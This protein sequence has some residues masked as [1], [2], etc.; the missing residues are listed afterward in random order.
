VSAQSRVLPDLGALRHRDYRLLWSGMLA[1]SALMPLQFTTLLLFL[2]DAAPE[3]LRLLLAGVLGAMRGGVML[4]VGIP[5]GALADRIPRRRLLLITQSVAIVA[6]AGIAGL[7]LAGVSGVGLAAIFALT[8]VAGGA[9]TVDTPA[10][11]AFVPQLVPREQLANAIALDAVAMQLAFP[12][13][14]PLTGLLIERLGFGG[15]FSASLLGH[16]TVLL[17]VVQIR[18][19]G[20]PPAAGQRR[21]AMLLQM[22]E[23]IAYTRRTAAILWV[24]VL[25]LAV[26]AVGFPPVGTLGP[27][28]VTSVLGLSP[29]QFGFFGAMWGLGALIGSVAM[30]RPTGGERK[31]RLVAA[32][33]ISFAVCVVVWG[34]SRSVPLSGLVNL[35]LGC[36]LSVMQVS[37]RSV[38]QRTAPSTMQGRV[39]SLFMLNMGVSQFMAAPVGA[40]AQAFTLERVVP[41]L[42]WV[43]LALVVGIVVMRRAAGGGGSQQL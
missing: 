36:S 18:H 38:V 27:V 26:M 28:W 6:N 15:A 19:R 9:M 43:C 4:I 5:G 31:A 8:F 2:Q 35:V 7:M 1:M 39:L 22:R 12:L 21:P 33:A 10:R 37:A 13:S 20:R 24:I 40:L 23:G 3:N 29:A 34:Y 32:G 25:V 17:M 42:G 30:T 16:L 41:L 11:Q 14:L